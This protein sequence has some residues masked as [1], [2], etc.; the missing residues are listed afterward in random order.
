MPLTRERRAY[1]VHHVGEE[2]VA[3]LE[4][5]LEEK[6]EALKA[7]DVDFKEVLASCIDCEPA[8]DIDKLDDSPGGRALKQLFGRIQQSR[9]V[10]NPNDLPDNPGGRALKSLF[11]GRR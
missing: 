1:L 4:K 8:D 2:R 11:G 5:G 9:H 7:G 6:E 10:V 3:A